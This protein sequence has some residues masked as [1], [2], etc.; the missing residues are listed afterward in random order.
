VNRPEVGS[1]RNLRLLLVESTEA[2]LGQT[3]V[4]GPVE[5]ALPLD[6]YHDHAA[7]YVTHIDTLTTHS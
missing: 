5:V 2:V 4:N 1:F 6:A 7:L 3:I